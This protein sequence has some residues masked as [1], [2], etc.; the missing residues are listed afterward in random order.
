M[1]TFKIKRGDPVVVIQ[2]AF[3][4]TIGTVLKIDLKN[5]KAYVSG[6]KPNTKY[7]KK[8][9]S[10]GRTTGLMFDVPRPVHISNIMFYEEG[11]GAS[12]ISVKINS[13]GVKTRVAKKTGTVLKPPTKNILITAK[14]DTIEAID[15]KPVKKTKA[16]KEDKVESEPKVTKPSKKST[17]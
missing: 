17:K 2:G 8:N 12:R 5:N 7:K 3:K 1:S 14:T 4:G 9:V 15:V 13:D 10:A 6:V 16:T 11:K